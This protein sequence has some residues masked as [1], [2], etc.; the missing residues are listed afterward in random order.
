MRGRGAALIKRSSSINLAHTGSLH[1]LKLERQRNLNATTIDH[2]E[3]SC[4]Q[5]QHQAASQQ[6]QSDSLKSV[7]FLP[8]NFAAKPNQTQQKQ[9]QDPT[10]ILPIE[11]N[12]NAPI[13][14]I[15]PNRALNRTKQ[16]QLLQVGPDLQLKERAPSQQQIGSAKSLARNSSSAANHV[17]HFARQ[18]ALGA[19]QTRSF[20]I[21]IESRPE[22]GLAGK[23]LLLR[24]QASLTTISSNVN[25]Q[26]N[27]VNNKFGHINPGD[28]PKMPQAFRQQQQ[29]QNRLQFS[30]AN[31][32]RTRQANSNDSASLVLSK[33]RVHFNHTF[34]C[35]CIFVIDLAEVMKIFAIEIY[36]PYYDDHV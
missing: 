28:A 34:A 23:R 21:P 4:L 36:Y 15:S 20:D 17:V 6:A 1:E 27:R 19:D 12:S 8:P 9:I 13:A 25:T 3:E 2:N 11:A 30:G 10:K 22:K 24:Q 5:Q 31:N 32:N 29:Q 18:V 26:A 16:E 33:H 14:K 35:L 7:D